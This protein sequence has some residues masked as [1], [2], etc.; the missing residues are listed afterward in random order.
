MQ[1]ENLLTN[2]KGSR[3][4]GRERKSASISGK[5]KRIF[6]DL[7]AVENFFPYLFGAEQRQYFLCF[8]RIKILE[9]VLIPMICFW[10]NHEDFIRRVG[11]KIET[12]YLSRYDKI[13]ESIGCWREAVSIGKRF[14]KGFKKWIITRHLAIWN[15]S[16]VLIHYVG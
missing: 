16:Y 7:I 3:I 2:A 9:F 15:R 10:K 12:L 6:W 14:W 1:E 8:R 13:N 11:N 4:W 5:S